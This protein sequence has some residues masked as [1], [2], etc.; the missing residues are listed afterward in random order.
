MLIVQLSTGFQISQALFVVVDT[1]VA[2]CLE[3]EGPTTVG[4]LAERTG[5]RPDRLARLLRA[6]VPVGVL[7]LDEAGRFGVTEAG[8]LLSETHPASQAR[9]V[10]MW[11]Q[12]NYLPFSELGH[13]VRTDTP[14]GERYLGAPFW[15]WL[16]RDPDRAQLF[17]QAMADITRGL[18]AGMFEGYRLPPGRVVADLGGA[19]GSLLVELLTRDRGDRSRRGILFD[20]PTTT[21]AATPVLTAAGLVDRVEVVGGDFFVAVPAADVYVLA[22]VLH[23]WSDEESHRILT[24][25][26]RAAR[27]GARLLVIEALLPSDATDSGL[28]GIFDLTMLGLLPGQERTEQHYRD[29]LDGAG[30]TVE[31]VVGTS[32]PY[33]I[34][35]A[36]L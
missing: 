17:S 11:M 12:I 33:S 14:G 8:A 35:E 13:S 21:P 32:T 16:H 3:Q 36:V 22:H 29:L 2:T 7:T 6:L 24:T 4:D 26:A 31:R 10:R 1:G 9:L 28:A 30:F 18:R 34:V 23:D 20:L 19:D 25:I 27:S 15:E 5:T